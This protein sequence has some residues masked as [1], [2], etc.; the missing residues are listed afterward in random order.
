MESVTYDI[1]NELECLRDY[2]NSIQKFYKY[3]EIAKEKHFDCDVTYF[4]MENARKIYPFL[5]GAEIKEQEGNYNNYKHKFELDLKVQ[6]R[7]FTYSGDTCNSFHTLYNMAVMALV[8]EYDDI[9]RRYGVPRKE[10]L[11]QLLSKH[12]GLS[13]E[14]EK[15][16]PLNIGVLFK[17]FAEINHTLPNMIALRKG[18]NA[19]RYRRTA[20]N[21]SFFL[22]ASY[23]YL[24]DREDWLLNWMFDGV[25]VLAKE[26]LDTFKEWESYVKL[27]YLESYLDKGVPKEFIK[28]QF[29][30]FRGAAERRGSEGK[31]KD[32]SCPKNPD[33]YV[34][35]LTNVI[36]ILKHRGAEM[37]S[38]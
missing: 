8:P 7:F 3:R 21:F 27:N 9:C 4:A 28:G 34:E 25:S 32:Y 5:T 29:K 12:E 10:T 2:Q 23:L 36:T 38:V 13:E 26:Y 17:E 14:F 37:P 22:Y 24:N 20:D 31:V 18:L 15:K 35:Y 19:P 6:G 1:K 11:A 33:E 16:M 30:R